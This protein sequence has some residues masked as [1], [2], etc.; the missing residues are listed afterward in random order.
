MVKI[1]VI[2]YNKIIIIIIII[3]YNNNSIIKSTFISNKLI[4]IN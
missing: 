3:I 1:K 2:L 4:L